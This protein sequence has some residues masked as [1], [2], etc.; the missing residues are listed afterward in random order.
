MSNFFESTPTI[1][2]KI[3]DRKRVEISQRIENCSI[4]KLKNFIADVSPCRGFES[5]IENALLEKGT[6][7]IAEIKKASPSKGLIRPNF[8]PVI[9][10]KNYEESG[11]TCLSVLT[12][13]DFFQGSDADLVK[14]R[15]SCKLPVIRKDFIIDPY[16]VFEARSLGAD[17]ILLIAAALSDNELEELNS[18]AKTLKMDVLIEVHNEEELKRALPLGNKL[19]GINNRDLHKFETNL[20]NTFDLLKDIPSDRI[21]ITESGIKNKEDI[22]IMRSKNVNA[23]LVGESLMSANNPGEKLKNL[24]FD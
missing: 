23:F 24:F 18:C 17:C 19:I 14:A 5:A 2:K 7:V 13:I 22:N 11:A 8:D 21:V 16:Q 6:A 1:L 4:S 20:K 15:E 9:I 3:L 12:D 10:A